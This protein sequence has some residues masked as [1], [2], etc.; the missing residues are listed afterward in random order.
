[1]R[2]TE[3]E[4]STIKSAINSRFGAVQ[5]IMLFGSRVD[6]VKRGGDIDL[7]VETTEGGR[8]AFLHQA[9]A[10][11]DIQFALGDRK[12]DMIVAHPEGSE[13]DLR[14]TRS[15]VKISRATGIV[16]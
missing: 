2:L 1:M 16:L 4:I 15:V 7:L 9:E 13:E 3:E 12:I 10:K 6:D 8:I 14:D 5:R 11:S